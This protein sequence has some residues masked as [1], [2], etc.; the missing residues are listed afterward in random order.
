M[1]MLNLQAKRACLTKILPL[2]HQISRDLVA[3]YKW[4]R[5][6]FTEWHIFIFIIL[7]SNLAATT[8][9][10]YGIKISFYFWELIKSEISFPLIGHRLYFTENAL[11]LRKCCK[12]FIL[13]LKFCLHVLCCLKSFSQLISYWGESHH[14]KTGFQIFQWNRVCTDVADEVREDGPISMVTQQVLLHCT[15]LSV[16][17]WGSSC[18]LS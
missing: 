5:I 16:A 3:K 17:Y 7:L 4:L 15:V 18:R 9:W 14:Q 11:G 12:F 13:R 8:K 10:H 1:L 2:I 6:W